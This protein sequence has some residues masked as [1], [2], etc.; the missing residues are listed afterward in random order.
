MDTV[1]LVLAAVLAV[2]ASIALLLVG[3]GLVS[4]LTLKAIAGPLRERVEANVP[5]SDVVRLDLG[6]NSFG[7][8]S[9][10]PAQARGNGALVLTPTALRFFQLVPAIEVAVPLTDIREI[11]LVRSHLGKSVG[12]RLVKVTFGTSGGSDAI[13]WFVPEP[14]AW[15]E[16]IET[17]RSRVGR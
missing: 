12:Y 3:I 16:A 7:L 8:S 10:G 15:A 1:L 4:R 9:K 11:T 17:A 2:V 6:A 5:S 13:A 14:E